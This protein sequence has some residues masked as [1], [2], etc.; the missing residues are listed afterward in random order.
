MKRILTIQDISCVGKC[1]L[2]V[3]LPIISAMG[4][5]AAVIPTAVLS[6]HTAFKGF[7]FRDLTG[8]IE[9]II[10]HWQAEGIS[11][12]AL[13][14]GYLGSLAQI[15]LVGQA[16]DAFK[17]PEN[18]IVIDPVMGDHG[19]L[20]AGFTP[21]FARE[22]AK[23]CARADVI[24]PNMTEACA[25]LDRPY[26]ESGYDEAEIRALLAQLTAL[27]ARCAVL[28]GVS[29]T[30]GQVGVMAYDARENRFESYFREQ[31]PVSFHGTGDIFASTT[32][33]ALARGL[34]LT[35]ALRVAVDFT[36]DSIALTAA[37]P[38]H[39]WYGVNFEQALPALVRR[40]ET[41]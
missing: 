38:D 32:V 26:I 3:A 28:T 27:G 29:F 24:V 19:K 33:G 4:V 1:S 11:F 40:M 8:D 14:T 18:Q 17:T 25:M 35:E 7:T 39:R 37:D 15:Q 21:E 22:M 10:R 31:V 9:P 12:D 30:P 23:L 16:F 20:Y 5:E 13:Y 34:T 41:T 2:T 6:T 36:V